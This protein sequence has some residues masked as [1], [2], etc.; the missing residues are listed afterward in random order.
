MSIGE[1]D[2][3]PAGGLGNELAAIL[4]EAMAVVGDFGIDSSEASGGKSSAARAAEFSARRWATVEAD[5][6]R[7]A[8]KVLP[9]ATPERANDSTTRIIWLLSRT[10]Y[11]KNVPV[12]G[13]PLATAI[14]PGLVKQTES[15]F[16][17]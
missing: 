13:G 2:I 17:E 1:S 11:W 5:A 6:R 15:Q 8:A 12:A 16:C 4:R 3:G 10:P 7:C 9:P 14:P